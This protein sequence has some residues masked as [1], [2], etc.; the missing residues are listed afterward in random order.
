MLKKE[1]QESNVDATIKN[2]INAE[3]F[4]KPRQKFRIPRSSNDAVLLLIIILQRR[5]NVNR[6]R[7]RSTLLFP[8]KCRSNYRLTYVKCTWGRAGD[9]YDRPAKSHWAR[10]GVMNEVTSRSHY[11]NRSRDS[12]RGASA[13]P[14]K[15]MGSLFNCLVSTFRLFFIVINIIPENSDLQ[16][17]KHAEQRCI[18][19]IHVLYKFARAKNTLLP[20]RNSPS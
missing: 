5:A 4:R 6:A 14:R 10:Q 18:A 8:G 12:S 20:W 15:K 1:T 13:F 9:A 2:F 3:S 19:F 7:L 17:A 11:L 16:L